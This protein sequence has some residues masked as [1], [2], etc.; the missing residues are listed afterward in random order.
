MRVIWYAT[1]NGAVAHKLRI[2]VFEVLFLRTIVFYLKFVA[3][4]LQLRILAVFLLFSL[5]FGRS[6]WM[7]D[8]YCDT[9]NSAQGGLWR[10]MSQR[11]CWLWLQEEPS[12]MALFVAF[13]KLLK[14]TQSSSLL[15][16]STPVLLRPPC[17]HFLKALAFSVMADPK[18]GIRLPLG[19]I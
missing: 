7:L 17:S 6:Y 5:G 13:Q 15:S 12:L 10:I 11:H 9:S 18:V 4:Q 1:P 8:S 16:S 3:I 19:S 2:T 14:S